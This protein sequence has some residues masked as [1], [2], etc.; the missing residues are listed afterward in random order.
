MIIKKF[1][2]IDIASPKCILTWTERNLPNGKI[3][4]KIEKPF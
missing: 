3:I 4:G 1:F 2:K